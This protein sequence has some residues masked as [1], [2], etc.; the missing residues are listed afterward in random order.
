MN[1]EWFEDQ[2][3]KN[4]MNE[5]FSNFPSEHH[6]ITI[7]NTT[8]L[9]LLKLFPNLQSENISVIY[10]GIDSNQFSVS[11]RLFACKSSFLNCRPYALVV[12]TIE[13]RK[14]IAFA[15]NSFLEYKRCNPASSLQLVVIGGSG[16]GNS[17]IDDHFNIQ[18]GIHFLGYVSDIELSKIYSRATMFLFPSLYEGFGFP[19]LEAMS[20]GVPVLSSSAPCMP[21]I[22]ND[23][24]LYFDP[25]DE[26]SLVSRI[27]EL[28]D[29]PHLRHALSRNGRSFCLKYNWETY[30]ETF[31]KILYNIE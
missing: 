29:N 3:V 30:L 25:R 8:K 21:E 2:S 4:N 12:G 27:Q 26:N 22:L 24:C 23:S 1:P 14:N 11:H 6:L 20:H 9:D 10:P 28:Y 31:N 19:P 5:F 15:I 13:P 7:S 17:I 16:W 18:N